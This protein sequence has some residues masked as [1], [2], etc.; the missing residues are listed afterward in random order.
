MLSHSLNAAQA[1]VETERSTICLKHSPFLQKFVDYLEDLEMEGCVE[2]DA[3]E[4]RA[5]PHF[6]KATS[7]SRFEN[8]EFSL[9]QSQLHREYCNIFEKRVDLFLKSNGRTA[10]D[11]YR[12]VSA[13]S[14]TT[15]K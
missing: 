9:I 7:N 8:T 3:F 14:Q 11:V 6:M 15:Y 10:E 13:I 5:M 2:L 4:T 1:E 12:Q